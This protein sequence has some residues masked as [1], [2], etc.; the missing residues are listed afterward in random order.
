M[1]CNYNALWNSPP[2]ATAAMTATAAR[3]SAAT[4]RGSTTGRSTSAITMHIVP[5]IITT[6][7]AAPPPTVIPPPA[8]ATIISFAAHDADA[9][10][11]SGQHCNGQPDLDPA[12]QTVHKIQCLILLDF[13]IDKNT[14]AN[15]PAA[16]GCFPH[17]PMHTAEAGEL[18]A[19]FGQWICLPG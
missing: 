19:A 2:A 1:L 11:Q 8:T 6:A 10:R 17:A 12:N 14:S 4:V 15:H 5:P 9:S 18:L 7:T 13:H 16:M 3:M